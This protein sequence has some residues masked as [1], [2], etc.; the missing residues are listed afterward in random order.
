MFR[1][2]L[3]LFFSVT[4]L[5]NSPTF[6]VGTE[7]II[8]IRTTGT[9]LNLGDDSMSGMKDIGFDFTFYNQTFDQVNIS[10]N[11]FFTFQ[12]NFSVSRSRNYRS[13]VIPATSFNYTVFTLWTDLIN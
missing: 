9:A 2:I 7:S 12:D 13:E 3:L 1:L 10:M 6:T 4:T 11:G 5:A 8:D